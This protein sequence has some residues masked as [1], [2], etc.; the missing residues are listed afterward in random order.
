MIGQSTSWSAKGSDEA[1][2]CVLLKNIV[3]R[4]YRSADYNNRTLILSLPFFAASLYLTDLMPLKPHSPSLQ[5]LNNQLQT[6]IPSITTGNI[7]I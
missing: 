6:V 1:S 3:T 5:P 4:Y 2:L 7:E